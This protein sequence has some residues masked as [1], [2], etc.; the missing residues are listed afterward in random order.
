MADFVDKSQKNEDFI[1]FIKTTE[2]LSSK[3]SPDEYLKLFTE[4]I[5]LKT[6]SEDFFSNFLNNNI[7]LDLK[8][9]L[10]NNFVLLYQK[11]LEP[12]KSQE[13]LLILKNWNI[14]KNVDK[15]IMRVCIRKVCSVLIE[16]MKS[17][18]TGNISIYPNLTIFL[19]K[20]F[21]NAST[22]LDNIIEELNN[23][24]LT[25]PSSNLLE[26]YFIILYQGAKIFPIT[27]SFK[28]HIEQ[29]IKD[30]AGNTAL[31]LYYKLILVEKNDRIIFLFENLKL[32]PEYT[33]KSA[34]FVGYPLRKDDRV[35]LFNYLYK[36]REK[37]FTN[38]YITG[39]DYYKNS[40]KAITKQ[41]LFKL[42]F[43]EAMKI[44]N[45]ETEFLS[46]FKLF[47]PIKGFDEETYNLNFTLLFS[48]FEP[49]RLEYNTLNNILLFF[50]QFYPISRKDAIIA[51]NSA[52][53]LLTNS[54]LNE[55][56][57][58]IKEIKEFEQ[59]KFEVDKYIKLIN[60]IFFMEIYN[61]SKANYQNKP[62]KE[63]FDFSIEELRKLETI[64]EK[65]EIKDLDKEFIETLKSAG[66]KNRN[67]INDEL[68][69]L[70]EFFG[71]N[72]NSEQ[73]DITKI[74]LQLEELIPKNIEEKKENLVKKEVVK[75]RAKEN[76]YLK[77]L[78][79][80]FNDC[81]NYYIKNPKKKEDENYYEKYIDYFK[82]LFADKELKELNA[83][84][85]TD[86][87]T[88]KMFIIYYT[89]IIDFTDGIENKNDLQ[90]IKDLFEIINVY[91]SIN[92]DNLYSISENIKNLLPSINDR[93]SEKGSK[94]IDGLST[95]FS[96]IVENDKKKEKNFSTCFINIL[97]EEIIRGRIKN[98]PKYLL[99]FIFKNDYLIENCIPLLDYYFED[100]FFSILKKRNIKQD[101]IIY[102]KS[103]NLA[104]I[105]NTLTKSQILR[106]QLLYYFETNINK[107]LEETYPNNEFIQSEIIKLYFKKINGYFKEKPKDRGLNHN[108]NILFFISFLKVF[109]T[110]YINKI[111]KHINLRDDTYDSFLA[112][113]NFSLVNSLSYFIL[114][115]YLDIDGNFLD[116]LKL[117]K[118]NLAK[119]IYE[120]IGKD[121]NKDFGFDYLI[122]PFNEKKA[123]QFCDNFIQVVYCLN[124]TNGFANDLGIIEDINTNDIDNF[125]CI[126]SNIFLS[127]LSLE[128][129][130]TKEEYSIILNW[131]NQKLENDSFKILNKYS[132][133]L[134]NIVIGMKKD[135]LVKI[136]YNKDLINFI[137]SLRFV[138]NSLYKE[139]GHF[140]FELLIDT[141]NTIS[142]SK[143][144]F[145]YFFS[146]KE[147]KEKEKIKNGIGFKLQPRN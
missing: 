85:F 41:E 130:T 143:N 24:E 55:F 60:S 30:N 106:E 138:L 114:K 7:N 91:K 107:I 37:Y 5:D 137:F 81:L 118:I 13:D 128:N 27:N 120:N 1:N 87:V 36:D 100:T 79:D 104:I 78:E 77:I 33:V 12:F 15:E 119:E 61:T 8:K 82:G 90:L 80:K 21:S 58:K 67:K 108:I 11:L 66:K 89:I 145:D 98:E 17:S 105:E 69:F 74:S 136:E 47:V 50:N 57:K 56:D 126:I 116:F 103:S 123:I 40:I 132:K 95:L 39:T 54:P 113:E 121:I 117:N 86:Y 109:Y 45:N 97:I 139:K 10:G 101:T 20:L 18:R 59:Y 102:F 16:E 142:K 48:E 129:Y 3:I 26:I 38:S 4:L 147:E 112:K 96:M 44:Y 92:N 144:I 84:D 134:I 9:L 43:T 122:L 141:S 73:F 28:E 25:F 29:Y 115:L 88:K 110:K 31:S 35:M 6:A 131:L 52:K 53:N 19:C 49:Y 93:M 70:K 23:F 51:L 32:K 133:N 76:K 146:S 125:Y 72:K 34:D 14:S 2:G 124:D 46:L 94:I 75:M 99:D 140:L 42:T 22:K 71:I 63:H 127:K 68:N 64:K 62:E 135:N 83:E 111:E 65:S